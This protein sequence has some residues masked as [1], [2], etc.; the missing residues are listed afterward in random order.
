MHFCFLGFEVGRGLRTALSW[1]VSD[2]I[3]RDKNSATH[4]MA[5]SKT[6]LRLRC[7]RA[8]HSMYLTALIS[9]ATLIACSY[10]MGAIFFCLRLSLVPSSSRRSSLV[11][12]RMMG[13]PGAWCSISGCHCLFCQTLFCSERC[14]CFCIPYLC[15]YVVEGRGADDGETDEEDVCLRVRKG[16]KT[17][18]IL[19]TSS[20]P[21]T[22]TDGLAI[23]HDTGRVVVEALNRQH[24][25]RRSVRMADD[26][27]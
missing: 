4:L 10:W 18:V 19:L 7:V 17:V 13:T 21:E 6:L 2:C 9:L 23:N 12:T 11:P 22:E 14:V 20:I 5:S 26:L 16:T 3:L 15:L 24:I 27:V 25:S 1:T 8:E